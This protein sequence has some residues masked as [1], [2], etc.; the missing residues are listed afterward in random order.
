MDAPFDEEVVL[1]LPELEGVEL[2]KG[3]S[4]ELTGL[5]TA[6]PQLVLGGRVTFTGQHASMLG[7]ALVAAASGASS[8]GEGDAGAYVPLIGVTALTSRR[9]V[10]T[11]T[12]GNIVDLLPPLVGGGDGDNAGGG[13]GGAAK[14]GGGGR[15]GGRGRVGRGRG[16]GNRG[17]RPRAA[18]QGA[19]A[20]DPPEGSAGA[21]AG[22]SGA[23]GSA[24]EGGDDGGSR[25][26][27]GGGVEDESG[28]GGAAAVELEPPG[29]AFAEV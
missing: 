2:E 15:G 9:V 27:S 18:R 13:G 11:V 28:E 26:G 20:G 1:E 5:D 19:G 25:D 23:G 4:V 22:D 21:G 14:R 17:G 3:L 10:F 16:R 7:S 24:E 6:R 29:D 12:S 8:C